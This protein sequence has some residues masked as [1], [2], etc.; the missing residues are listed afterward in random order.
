VRLEKA[1]AQLEDQLGTQLACFTSTHVQI[2]TQPA[3]LGAVN[4]QNISNKSRSAFASFRA[5]HLS[6]RHYLKL[7]VYEALSY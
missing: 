6:R 4:I 7:L 1:K 5:E 3:L 2:L